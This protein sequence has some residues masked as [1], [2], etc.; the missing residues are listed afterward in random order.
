MI[1]IRARVRDAAERGNVTMLMVV[2]MIGIIPLLGLGI[3][4]AANANAHTQAYAVAQA[5]ARAGANVLEAGGAIDSGTVRVGDA[6]AAQARGYMDAA[7][8]GGSVT[9]EGDSLHVSVEKCQP[10][11]FLSAIGIGCLPVSASA[12]A[13]LVSR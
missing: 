8:Y 5:A 13:D 2:L 9:R 3:D 12:S 10:T 7:G 1:G 6:A 11:Q 4:G